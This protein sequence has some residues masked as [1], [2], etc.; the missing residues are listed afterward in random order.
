MASSSCPS[1][2]ATA[3]VAT[4]R[5]LTICTEE[6]P[7]LSEVAF[8]LTFLKTGASP[9][10]IAASTAGDRWDGTYCVV[11][12]RPD[13]TVSLRLVKGH[14]SFVDYVVY[15]HAN[16]VE[17]TSVPVLLMESTKTD[18]KD[19]RNTAINQRFT[20][21]AVARQRYPT[22][23]LVLF[24]NA[25]H[26]STTP[27]SLFGRR[28]LSTFGVGIF[29]VS[30]T[31]HSAPPFTTVDELMVAKNTM[32][33][34]AGNVSVKISQPTPHCYAISA[35]LT[36][37]AHKTISHDPNK[38]FLTGIATALFALDSAASF[39][40]TEH[41][42]DL[43]KLVKTDDKFWYAN[44]RYDMRLEGSELTTLNKAGKTVYWNPETQSE[45]AATILFQN[46]MESSGNR[47]IY[48]NHSSSARSFF[49]DPAG[50]SFAVP[51]TITIPDLVYVNTE[52]KKLYICEGKIEKCLALGTKQLDEQG[53]FMEYAQKY[54]PHYT[55]ERGLCL[56]ASSL[57][58][59][60]T[61]QAATKYPIWFV[62]DASG[63]YLSY[64]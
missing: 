60:P 34:K 12:N 63:R 6:N 64:A 49:L 11:T 16:P 39:R 54:Y 15:D 20:K 38:G 47:V 31:D 10:S 19:S 53:P 28:L 50:A 48:H 25:V 7:Q 52:L 51:K 35:R 41:G 18:D 3:A 32:K 29:D 13:V 55:I 42:V 59:V 30:G 8:I 61:L 46:R 36:N 2:T 17:A 1:E 44:S 9:L 57:E 24:F 43:T 26:T 4:P 23:P 45:K 14:G 22:A 5:V 58:K 21:F 56:Y 27:T 40:V 37:G 62:L 33:E